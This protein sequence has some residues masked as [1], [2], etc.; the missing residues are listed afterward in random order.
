[1]N[2]WVN[3]TLE[4]LSDDDLMHSIAP[5]KNHGVWLLGHL[6]ESEDEVSRYLGKG[7]MMFPGY[8]KLF[9]EGSM[10]QPPSIY[11][12]AS[13]LRE[14]WKQVSE[15]NNTMLG[16][17]TDDEL[18]DPLPHDNGSKLYQLMKTKAGCITFWNLHAMYHQGQ[19]G[20]IRTI[21]KK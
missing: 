5:G 8:E 19:L 10:L 21:V 7:D 4:T 3:R 9:G 12:E 6:I 16:S 17:L 14:Q 2:G 18:D 13:A 1:M 15:K 20:V 11:P